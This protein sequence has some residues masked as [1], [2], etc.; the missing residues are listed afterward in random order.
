MGLTVGFVVGND[1]RSEED[2]RWML[3]QAMQLRREWADWMAD[4]DCNTRQQRAEAVRNWNALSGVVK[5]L[6][7]MLEFPGIDDPLY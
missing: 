4:E 5:T 7:W 1:M 3:Q 6:Q 2:L